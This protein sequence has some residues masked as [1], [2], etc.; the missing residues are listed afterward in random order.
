MRPRTLVCNWVATS[1]WH[2]CRRLSI[3]QIVLF[4]SSFAIRA[5]IDNLI[6]SEQE[7]TIETPIEM[8]MRTVH[9]VAIPLTASVT[10]IIQ[11]PPARGRFELK[12]NIPLA[13]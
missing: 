12:Q 2:H 11:K 1:F 8:A 3:W 4:Q 9:D 10:S 5:S 6:L 13:H 7:I